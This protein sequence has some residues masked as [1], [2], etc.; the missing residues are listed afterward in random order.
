[1]TCLWFRPQEALLLYWSQ[2]TNDGHDADAANPAESLKVLA[3]LQR[4]LPS[5]CEDECAQLALVGVLLL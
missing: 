2:P 5:W 3:H 1:M 4:Q